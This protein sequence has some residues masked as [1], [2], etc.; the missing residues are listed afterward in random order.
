MS[1]RSLSGYGAAFAL[2]ALCTFAAMRYAHAPRERGLRPGISA[3]FTA[4]KP[5]RALG[6]LDRVGLQPGDILLSVN[7]VTDETMLKELVNGYNRGNVCVTLERDDKTQEVCI[8]RREV[9]SD[10]GR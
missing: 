5:D 3:V 10:A 8:K 2:G 9:A 1:L 7:G 4:N 6:G